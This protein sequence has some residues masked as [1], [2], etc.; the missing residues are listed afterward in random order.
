MHLCPKIIAVDVIDISSID[1]KNLHGFRKPMKKFKVKIP[2]SVLRWKIA[3]LSLRN[4]FSYICWT[5]ENFHKIFSEKAPVMSSNI[6]SQSH[7]ARYCYSERIHI[8]RDPLSTGV[9]PF[10]NSPK[11]AKSSCYFSI[12]LHIIL[13]KC[14]ECGMH[15]MAHM[16]NSSSLKH[17]LNIHLGKR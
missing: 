14:L 2:F 12:K 13:A 5:L 8:Q 11:Q 9:Q 16:E 3:T 10:S 15:S 6:I 1:A 4:F 17:I 7:A